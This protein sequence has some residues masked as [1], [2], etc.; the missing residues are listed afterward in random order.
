MW[1]D[2]NYLRQL[3]AKAKRPSSDC[4]YRVVLFARPQGLAHV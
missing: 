4:S 2:K 3:I 1:L